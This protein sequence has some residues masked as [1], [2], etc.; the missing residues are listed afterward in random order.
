MLTRDA[1]W[2]ADGAEVAHSLDAA[3]T[4]YS[5]WAGHILAGGY[6]LIHDIFLDPSQGGQ[7]PHE[8]YRLACSSGRFSELPMTGPLGVL[9]CK[10][11]N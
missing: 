11:T 7:A 1:D 3:L 10:P 8:I 5:L 2:Q 6:L 9:Q 4:D